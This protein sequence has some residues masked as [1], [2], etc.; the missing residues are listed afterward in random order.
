VPRDPRPDPR[1]APAPRRPRWAAAVAGCVAL[2]AALIFV[3]WAKMETVQLTYA[4][5]AIETQERE[6]DTVQRR[7]RAEL[8][9]LRGPSSLEKLAP[10]L[11]LIEPKA[12]QVV[13]ITE[14]PEGL[15]AALGAEAE[16]D[17]APEGDQR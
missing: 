7:L 6:L 4:I 1:A 11:G 5:G 15:S 17:D 16:P 10:E 9:E 12:A 3:A 14:D 13:V 2:A 8:G